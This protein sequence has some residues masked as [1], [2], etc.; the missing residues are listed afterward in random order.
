MMKRVAKNVVYK[1]GIT[2]ASFGADALKRSLTVLMYHR[3]IAREASLGF[4]SPRDYMINYRQFAAS[5]D[6]V[7][8]LYKPVSIAQI[9]AH[10]NGDEPLPDRAAFITFDDGWIDTLTVAAPE[11]QRRGVPSIVF[12]PPCIFDGR[13]SFWQ[14]RLVYAVGAGSVALGQL[15]EIV[16]TLRGGNTAPSVG[17]ESLLLDAIACMT[18]I[19][20]TRREAILDPL[21]GDIASKEQQFITRDD[22]PRLAHYGVAV[23]AHGFSH[24]AL[25]TVD[26][27]FAQMFHS[28]V[29]LRELLGTDVTAMSFPQGRYTS[30]IAAQAFD[31]GYQVVFT[32]DVI[33][34]EQ[35]PLRVGRALLGRIGIYPDAP[36]RGE[37]ADTLLDR[38]LRVLAMPESSH[39]RA[40]V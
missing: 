32:S 20:P 39:A 7:Q 16:E 36:S 28:R 34:N 12:I 23:G 14:E 9:I 18:E 17:Q 5:L 8:R 13:H 40:T 21:I 25:T 22:C 31:A 38:P 30:A 24:D 6:V 3:V 26:D 4:A 15:R 1:L 29:H 27:P 37:I 11:L 2:K 19:D 33:V 10:L 35:P